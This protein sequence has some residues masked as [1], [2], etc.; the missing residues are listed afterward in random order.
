MADVLV[1]SRSGGDVFL[2]VD[3]SVEVSLFKFCETGAVKSLYWREGEWRENYWWGFFG[4]F[5]GQFVSF[6]I[7]FD[8][9]VAFDPFY[10]LFAF[11]PADPGQFIH[12]FAEV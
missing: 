7:D 2:A 5:F 3:D 4:P 10:S 1:R 12:F 8:A 9:T 6:L 11:S